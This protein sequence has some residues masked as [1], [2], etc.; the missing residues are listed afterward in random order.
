MDDGKLLAVGIDVGTRYACART[1]VTH[2]N[3]FKVLYCEA[4]ATKRRPESPRKNWIDTI[5]QDLK[6][7]VVFEM[8][9]KISSRALNPTITYLLKE[10]RPVLRGNTRALFWQ[11]RLSSI[12]VV[13]C[14]SVCLRHSINYG[15]SLL[16]DSSNSA[17]TGLASC[18]SVDVVLYHLG[19]NFSVWWM[20]EYVHIESLSVCLL[21]SMHWRCARRYYCWKRRSN[22]NCSGRATERA[23]WSIRWPRVPENAR[24]CALLSYVAI[25]AS[26]Q[27]SALPSL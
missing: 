5:R 12:S 25:G 9:C 1:F 15:P 2:W 27:A 26:Q 6:E 11:R 19:R 23:H 4:N 16:Y 18:L 14:G 8:T 24:H 10:N 20:Y 22:G 21:D 7:T 13:V 17:P 3:F